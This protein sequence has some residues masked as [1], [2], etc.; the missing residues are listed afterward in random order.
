MAKT[1]GQG[2]WRSGLGAYQHPMLSLLTAAISLTGLPPHIAVILLN[3]LLASLVL[4]PLSRLLKTLGLPERLIWVVCA[5]LMFYPRW[6]QFSVSGLS[7]V[8]FG[9]LL[10]F[11]ADVLKR[12]LSFARV[13]ALA[14]LAAAGYLTKTEGVLLLGLVPICIV[15]SARYF[16]TRVRTAVF[17]ASAFALLFILFSWPYLVHLKNTTGAWTF[18]P[19]STFASSTVSYGNADAGRFS[20]QSDGSWRP[21][22]QSPRKSLFSPRH[23]LQTLASNT[24]FFFSRM[25]KTV[26]WPLFALWMG[27]LA[28]FLLRLRKT[29][30]HP[31]LF[32]LWL[33]SAVYLS[34]YCFFYITYR[35]YVPCLPLAFFWA[36]YCIYAFGDPMKLPWFNRI[37]AGTLALLICLSVGLA[38]KDR[39]RSP[40]S[41]GDAGK[42]AKA[43]LPKERII[44]LH[45]ADL[46]YYFG[47][48]SLQLPY[49]DAEGLYRYAKRNNAVYV[50]IGSYDVKDKDCRRPQLTELFEKGD[51]RFSVVQEFVRGKQDQYRIFRIN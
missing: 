48:E 2:D 13:P 6:Y 45:G 26:V 49:T 34:F 11:L 15:L 36:A 22:P 20:L 14:A 27:G 4:F 17:Q 39:R 44:A 47:L 1:L 51:P 5:G 24:P 35:F 18:T 19:K 28:L 10:V 16:E 31:A 40:F 12:E 38:E 3:A 33:F 50:M 30:G 29:R 9:T 21:M 8:L 37:S 23:R 32:A 42:W 46:M 7:E 43:N 41:R 25:P